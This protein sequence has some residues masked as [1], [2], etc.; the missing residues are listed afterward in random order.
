MK[1]TPIVR[2]DPEFRGR[3]LSV[4]KPARA[5]FLDRDGV[6]NEEVGYL[7]HSC[8]MRFMRGIFPLCQ[9][10]QQQGY[11]LIIITNQSG[12]ARGYYTEEQYQE[13]TAWMRERFLRE[14]VT[15]DA[16]Y[17]APDHPDYPASDPGHGSDW[18]KP[19]PG[20]L[21]EAQRVFGLDMAV[22]VFVGDKCTDVKAGNAA[23][24]GKM[25][26]IKGVE[27]QDCDGQYE[28]MQD[29]AAVERW[30]TERG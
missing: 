26:L 16:V 12:I 21:L 29:L 2:Q 19:G 7:V 20:M 27:T 25:F 17:H 1:T 28:R 22:S 6:V 4:N 30:L 11:K 3:E 14:G 8:D 5:V 10:A 18:R 15:L 13:L 9:T 23:G 24:V